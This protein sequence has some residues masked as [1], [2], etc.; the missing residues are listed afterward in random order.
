MIK[1]KQQEFV[2]KERNQMEGAVAKSYFPYLM[3]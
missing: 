1:E 2:E 3:W